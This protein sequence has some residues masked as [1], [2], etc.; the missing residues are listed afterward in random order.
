MTT[1]SGPWVVEGRFDG[2][3]YTIE[4]TKKDDEKYYATWTPDV[5][6]STQPQTF[7][8]LAP[9]TYGPCDSKDEA[10][11]AMVELAQSEIRKHV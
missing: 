1:H 8:D 7:W 4:I 11:A 5:S 10:E 3:S 9:I 6:E 2:V